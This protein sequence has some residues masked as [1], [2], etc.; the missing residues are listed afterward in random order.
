MDFW[1]KKIDVSK[2]AA[3]QQIAIINS[4]PS[5]KRLSIALNFAD[6]GVDQTF[7]WIRSNHPEFSELEIRL[8]FVRLLSYERGKIT[9]EHWK[10]F[11]SVMEDRIRKDWSERFRAMMAAKD[12][13][14]K[15]VAKF[16]R[17]KNGK[18]IEATVS[19]GLPAFAKLA[20]VLFEESEK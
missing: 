3:S 9:E 10:H 15:D 12:W 14:Y 1:G 13:T 11:K 6:M 16:G 2:E 17:F 19:R 18:V 7:A 8:E 5:D 4:F 20:V